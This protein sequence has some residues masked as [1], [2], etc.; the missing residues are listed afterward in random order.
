M[1]RR[2]TGGRMGAVIVIV[3]IWVTTIVFEP[4][5]H[6][7]LDPREV[8]GLGQHF[9]RRDLDKARRSLVRESAP[10]SVFRNAAGA[11]GAGRGVEASQR[12][13]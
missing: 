7:R 12:R 2:E 3:V 5:T 1:A 6:V 10:R 9:T 13:L 8:F 4:L 11:H